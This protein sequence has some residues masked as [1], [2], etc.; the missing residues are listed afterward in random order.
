M[1]KAALLCILC[2]GISMNAFHAF[3]KRTE[4]VLSAVNKV[5][6]ARETLIPP[7]IDGKLDDPCWKESDKATSFIQIEPDRGKPSVG[8]TTAMVLYDKK[9]LY[10]A[11]VA[12]EKEVN[13]IRAT[14]KRRDG[15][16]NI[17]ADDFVGVL[18]DTY[19]DHRSSYAFI[20]NPIGTQWDLSSAE[21]GSTLD[22]NWDAKW[23]AKCR[24]NEDSWTAELQ[25][26]FS[27]LSYK[28]SGDTWGINFIRGAKPS[29]E[30]SVWSYISDNFF[31]AAGFGD[32]RGLPL[33]E[34]ST[35]S[36]KRNIRFYSAVEDSTD[37]KRKLDAGVDLAYQPASNLNIAVTLNPDYADVEADEMTIEITDIERYLPERRPFF[38]EGGV[39]FQTPMMLFY[40]RRIMDIRYGA[41]LSGKISDYNLA[42]LGMQ[43]EDTL[44]YH[45]VA[46]LQRDV[47]SKS[48][49]G[50]MSVL[51]EKEEGYNRVQAVDALIAL[52]K[53][54]KWH[55]QLV[56]SWSEESSGNI[57]YTTALSKDTSPFTF[58]LSYEQIPAELTIEDGYVP[59]LD[60]RGGNGF[61]GYRKTINKRVVRDFFVKF[62]AERYENHQGKLTRRSV[63]LES[64]GVYLQNDIS[65]NFWGNREYHVPYD[66]N[67]IGISVSYKG[68]ELY[69]KRLS[70][71]T[72]RF[73]DSD[74]RFISSSAAFSPTRKGSVMLA[75]EANRRIFDDGKME[76][77]F[78][79][80]L[81]VL[82]DFS[83]NAFFRLSLRAMKGQ[84]YN[85]SGF[86]KYSPKRGMNLYV[87][88]GDGNAQDT[89][90]RVFIKFTL[91]L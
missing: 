11:I 40:S 65:I 14:L 47:L 41:K 76:D 3:A 62:W 27:E 29:E 81:S 90:H 57:A 88:Y 91:A 44:D 52:S 32:L 64:L 7:E 50:F 9:N 80:R 82:Y 51:K 6:E 71:G 16:G 78:L 56:G 8:Q 38:K 1:R 39:L 72:G 89:K 48:T 87:L 24:I 86:F 34:L 79:S 54:I 45:M 55:S 22:F 58:R 60:S 15:G 85:L 75:L 10:V 2:L 69:G 63:G 36:K 73:E 35:S 61:W 31:D 17:G 84:H 28:S 66:N 67:R 49:I 46:R 42:I 5:L 37:E 53:D 33:S 20:V 4:A 19:H 70:L 59:W 68:S 26:P 74:I 18:L 30:Y 77:N 21:G 13:K 12:Y 43:A 25:I 83:K 23:D